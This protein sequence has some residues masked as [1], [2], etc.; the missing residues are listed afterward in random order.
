MTWFYGFYHVLELRQAGKH[1]REEY[2]LQNRRRNQETVD[3]SY[4]K[5]HCQ[6]ARTTNPKMHQDGALDPKQY[7]FRRA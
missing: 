7:K 6:E 3:I 1:I 4:Y 5:N 2:V